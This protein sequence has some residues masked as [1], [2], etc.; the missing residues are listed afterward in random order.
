MLKI[1]KAFGVDPIET[2]ATDLLTLLQELAAFS[3]KIAAVV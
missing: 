2:G 3:I 1:L